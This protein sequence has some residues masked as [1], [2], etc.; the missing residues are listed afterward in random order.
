M[1]TCFEITKKLIKKAII[2][3]VEREG[4]NIFTFKC[5]GK[6]NQIEDVKID[7]HINGFFCL[8][9][10]VKINDYNW[11]CFQCNQKELRKIGE[12]LTNLAIEGA[13]I[14]D[15]KEYE[16]FKITIDNLLD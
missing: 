15:K 13:S 2:E 5:Y 7:F 16:N 1:E 3:T 14:R 8:M 9:I 6:N 12:L 10:D 11:L 4:D